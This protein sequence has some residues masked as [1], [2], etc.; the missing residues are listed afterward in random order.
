MSVPQFKEFL[1]PI[2]TFMSD[3]EL[4]KNKELREKVIE[5]FNLDETDIN[6]RTK[7]GEVTKVESKVNWTIQYLRR[8][9]LIQTLGRGDYRITPRGMEVYESDIDNFDI[10]YLVRFQEFQDYKNK[11]TKRKKSQPKETP[12]SPEE[13]KPTE[14]KTEE[15]FVYY[16]QEEMDGNIKIGWSNDP[17]KRLPQ[18]QTSNS[19]ELRML[20]YVKGS[21]D[22]E[23]EIHKKFQ[24]FK[25]TGEWF[26]PDKRLLVHIEKEKSKFFEIVQNLST[27]YEELKKRLEVIEERI[28]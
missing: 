28:K 23:T 5:Y 14:P 22:Y 10:D 3:G 4:H 18:H 15:G 2:L 24:N 25:T 11:K 20:V 1:K 27:D 12:S 19:R 8:S 6:E 7:G 13:P 17:I 16:I 9:V 26:K 21:Q